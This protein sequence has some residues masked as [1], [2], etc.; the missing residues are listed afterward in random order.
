[1]ARRSDRP[2]IDKTG[3]GSRLGPVGRRVEEAL[4][5]RDEEDTAVVGYLRHYVYTRDARQPVRVRRGA[6]GDDGL[7]SP[8][9][10]V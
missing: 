10:S 2:G 8:R 3:G 7:A 9:T 6:G 5:G 4:G 1:M